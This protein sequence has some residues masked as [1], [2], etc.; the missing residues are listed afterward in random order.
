MLRRRIVLFLRKEGGKSQSHFFISYRIGCQL[1]NI[2]Y[3][4][5]AWTKELEY[6]KKGERK[7][8]GG[9]YPKRSY[10]AIKRDEELLWGSKG[11]YDRLN[12][13]DAGGEKRE[14]QG[15]GGGN[16]CREELYP[17]RAKPP[18]TLPFPL[19]LHTSNII[20]MHTPQ[21]KVNRHPRSE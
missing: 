15:L 5:D 21:K 13:V 4:D 7:V 14:L 16:P 8:G 11:L 18:S 6:H 3:N 12:T 1:N 17:A 20:V 9:E 2:Y 19:S 10:N